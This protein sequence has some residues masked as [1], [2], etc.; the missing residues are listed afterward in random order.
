[1]GAL[2]AGHLSLITLARSVCDLVVVSIFVNPL[3]FGP[4]EDY[5][6]YPRTVETD[7]ETC[8]RVGSRPGL[9]PDRGRSLSGG[10]S[11]HGERRSDR[12]VCSR[13]PP[14]PDTSTGS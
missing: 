11:G 5:A 2:H 3:Q 6:L 9:R 4:S 1:M 14:D 12:H 7:L 13:A 10:P 8:R